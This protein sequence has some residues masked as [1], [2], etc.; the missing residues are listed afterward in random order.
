MRLKK[1]LSLLLA[2]ALSVSGIAYAPEIQPVQAA[3]TAQSTVKSA[4]SYGDMNQ[5]GQVALADA[6]VALKGALKIMTLTKEQIK[7]GDID[8]NGNVS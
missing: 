4:K 8:S 3:Q 6:Q 2:T 1:G 7:I 5:D